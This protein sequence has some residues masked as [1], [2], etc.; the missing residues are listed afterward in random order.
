MS[1]KIGG[2]AVCSIRHHSAIE[3]QKYDV[4]DHV[5]VNEIMHI[6]PSL[7]DPVLAQILID[8][9]LKP[10]VGRS[11]PP[12]ESR[13]GSTEL[14]YISNQGLEPPCSEPIIVALECNHCTDTCARF[15]YHFAR[16]NVKKDVET[17]EHEG[18]EHPSATVPCPRQTK[19]LVVHWPDVALTWPNSRSIVRSR[20]QKLDRRA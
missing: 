8:T 12:I 4:P 7:S 19:F 9:V 13:C 5:V 10:V 14:L 16:Y 1:A 3:H 20:V 2:R 18:I 6:P 15:S 17:G 11:R